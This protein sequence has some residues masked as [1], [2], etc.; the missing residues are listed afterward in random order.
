MSSESSIGDQEELRALVR[1]MVREEL[2]HLLR[3]TRPEI[4]DDVSHEGLEDPDGDDQ[5]LR[6]AL[7]TLQAH[8]ENP[9][10]WM[11]WD[12]FEAELDRAEATGELPS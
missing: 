8:H 3:Q 1:R 10:A 9:E 6:E 4:L 12:Q 7:A 5:L 2:K 11:D